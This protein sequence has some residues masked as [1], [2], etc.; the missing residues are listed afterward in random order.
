MLLNSSEV[1]GIRTAGADDLTGLWTEPTVP[2]ERID[3]E[4][5]VLTPAVGR[6]RVVLEQSQI[7]EGRLYAVG[8]GQVWIDSKNGRMGLPGERVHQVLRIDGDDDTPSLGGNEAR[9]LAGLESVRVRTLGGI[10]YGKIIAE[11][12]ESTTL[13]T[14][15][16]GRVT[17]KSSEVELL[18]K[19]PL[20]SILRERK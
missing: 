5:R 11:E 14:D 16:G 15:G 4:Q 1:P 18:S 17:L 19:V 20:V 10:F 7:F 9:F 6:V 2:L 12:G 8:Q 13:L 3:D